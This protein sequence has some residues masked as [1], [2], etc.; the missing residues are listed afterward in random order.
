M[1]KI[2]WMILLASLS[3]ALS[4]CRE[5][6]RKTQAAIGLPA[7]VYYGEGSET[8]ANLPQEAVLLRVNGVPFTR[9]DFD[10]DQTVFCKMTSF[11]RSGKVDC[12]AK[13]EAKIK[14]LRAPKV[15]NTVLHR[16]LLNQEAHRR[17]IKASPEAVSFRRGEME[18]LLR[19]DSTSTNGVATL[20]GLA[21]MLGPEC[22][23]YFIENLTKSAE[24]LELL[25]QVG[26]ERLKVTEDDVDVGTNRLAKANR[27]VAATNAVLKARL[28]DALN[29][30]KAGEDF[31]AVG[32]ELSMFDKDD[33]KEWGT[34][35]IEDFDDADYPE[36]AEFLKSRPVQGTVAGPFQCDDGVSI[37][38]VLSVEKSAEEN[39]GDEAQ[40]GGEA[41]DTIRYKLARIS[42]ET[43]EYHKSLSRAEIRNIMEE[44]KRKKFEAEFGK[45]LFESAVIEFP[46]GTNLFAVATSSNRQ[47]GDLT[48]K[49][50]TTTH[51]G[52][53]GEDVE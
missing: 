36:V 20:E 9:K 31:S 22:G 50:M 44:D 17:G 5:E 53:G 2:G 25:W 13:D 32:L 4:G 42:V 6:N 11:M 8:I 47:N 48:K 49:T 30:V 21:K 29:R 39:D 41:D 27:I 12:D 19:L 37:V 46:S 1:G 15:L 28:V 7:G 38:K 18:A 14:A 16:E 26:G 3:A 45:G 33:A 40:P 34:F 24:N 43:F 10:I 23:S 51:Q 35:S 52:K